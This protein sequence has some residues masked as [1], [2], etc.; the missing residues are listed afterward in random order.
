MVLLL[1]CAV[2]SG[3]I[4]SHDLADAAGNGMTC[5]AAGNSS[6]IEVVPWLIGWLPADLLAVLGV[7]LVIWDH[8][9]GVLDLAL[10]QPAG[11]AGP[12]CRSLRLLGA[13]CVGNV[14]VPF[15]PLA[16]Y[17]PATSAPVLVRNIRWIG[18]PAC[19]PALGDAGSRAYLLRCLITS[20]PAGSLYIPDGF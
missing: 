7:L 12:G 2:E 19:S 18:V 5:L 15:R 9:A 1:R 4:A 10:T 6:V 13:G 3:N 14:R 20:L 8:L 11:A 17:N 16:T